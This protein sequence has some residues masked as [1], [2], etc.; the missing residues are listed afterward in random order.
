MYNLSVSKVFYLVKCECLSLPCVLTWFLQECNWEMVYESYFS[1]LRRTSCFWSGSTNLHSQQYIRVPISHTALT[2]ILVRVYIYAHK[3]NHDLE[4]SW[5][6]KVYSVHTSILLF[7]TRGSQDSYSHRKG[8][9]RQELIQ[10]PA[11]LA[12]LQKPRLPTSLRP[13]PPTMDLIPL[14]P[15]D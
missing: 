14:I 9:W 8:T 7:T 12:F 10:R 5:G 13:A 4:P 1:F 2:T 6:G 11:K 3:K 15:L